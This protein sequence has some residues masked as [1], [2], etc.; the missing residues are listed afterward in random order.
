MLREFRSILARW[1]LYERRREMVPGMGAYGDAL[2]KKGETSH[3]RD[4][5][6]EA[7]LLAQPQERTTLESKL[8]TIDAALALERGVADRALI[9]RAC[10]LAPTDQAPQRLLNHVDQRIDRPAPHTYRLV[11]TVGILIFGL[12]FLGLLVVRVLPGA[13]AVREEDDDTTSYEDAG[14]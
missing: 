13:G 2:L 3:A 14:T 8:L 11:A 1:P 9:E 5:L 6:R 7:S 10:Q 4:V 12:A